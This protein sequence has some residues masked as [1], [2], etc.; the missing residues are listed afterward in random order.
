MSCHYSC[1][2]CSGEV[3]YDLCT[4]CPSTRTL[5]ASTCPC[6]SG[7]YEYQSADCL[8]EASAGI[9]DSLLITVAKISFFVAIGLHLLTIV[10]TLNRL[11]SPKIKKT[12]DTM[13]VIGLIAYYRFVQNEVAV[14]GLKVLIVFNFSY[15]S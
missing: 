10:L 3:Y 14:R 5:T 6:A 8:A 2:S 4:A 15:L 13:Q 9:F 11:V 1:T 7:Y 12:I